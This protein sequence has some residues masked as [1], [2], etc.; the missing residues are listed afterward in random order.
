MLPIFDTQ[1]AIPEAFRE[2]YEEKDGRWHPKDDGAKTALAEE[3][4]KREAAEK[5][6]T[7]TTKELKALETRAT[8]ERAGITD[9][10]LQKL[11]A[12]IRADL[13]TEYTPLKEKAD[14][15]GSENRT[16]KLDNA[17][18]AVMGA[19]DVK[20]RSARMDA[21][22]RLIGDRFDLT[23]D[24]KP[25]VKANP[26]VEV[27]KYLA[28]TVKKEYPEFYEGTAGSGGGAREGSQNRSAA[29]SADDILKNPGA[30]LQAARSQGKTE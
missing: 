21:L 22:W 6:V 30:A 11:R 3:R 19:E 13:E 29:V 27:K 8:A 18:K 15:F 24:G 12:E 17:V 2:E 28:E 20:V 26:G 16:L 4:T 7:K 10:Q 23:D 25:M 14:R 5:L 1:D 9:E